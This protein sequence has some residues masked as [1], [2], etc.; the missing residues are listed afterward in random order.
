MDAHFHLDMLKKSTQLTTFQKIETAVT[1]GTELLPL[2][3]AIANYVYP[4]SWSQ[5]CDVDEDER[6][7]FTVGLHP[8][9]AD[10]N[11]SIPYLLDFL[12]HPKC[13][14]IGE[15]GLNYTSSCRCRNH[16]SGYE[17]ERC[18][19]RKH[20][21]QEAFLDA[22]FPQLRRRDCTIVIHT[23]GQGGDLRMVDLLREFGLN[24]HRVH[25]HCFMG[26]K[27]IASLI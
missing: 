26:A 7:Y 9:M 1:F 22:L 14:R 11:M 2:T 20:Q 3:C 21:Q 23:N 15:I 10:H 17:R 12:N 16:Q 27:D 25:W 13:V 5:I 8:H 19:K 6:L 18:Q 4:S 24:N